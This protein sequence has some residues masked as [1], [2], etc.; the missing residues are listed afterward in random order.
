MPSKRNARVFDR[1]RSASPDRRVL[2][3]SR[4]VHTWRRLSQR[5]LPVG[6]DDI[7]LVRVAR[8][9]MDV[10]DA[11]GRLVDRCELRSSPFAGPGVLQ[12]H[13][14]RSGTC[15]Y[16]DRNMRADTP[17]AAR[18]EAMI[19]KMRGVKPSNE[20]IAEHATATASA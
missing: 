3:A 12:T 10:Q 8:N 4:L 18:P 17:Q 20:P 2:R 15:R 6:Y 7:G 9:V 13:P 5:L 16:I 19:S 1:D 14:G 11:L